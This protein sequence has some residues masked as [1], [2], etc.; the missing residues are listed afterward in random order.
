MINN[1][2]SV[3]IHS[4]FFFLNKANK[5]LDIIGLQNIYIS[6]IEFPCAP[7]WSVWNHRVDFCPPT[8][9]FSR[10]SHKLLS[11]GTALLRVI[12]VFA[13]VS[14]LLLFIVEKIVAIKPSVV[15]HT[16][17]VNTLGGWRQENYKFKLSLGNLVGKT[18]FQSKKLK[19]NR[20]VTWWEGPGFNS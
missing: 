14:N 17:S 20:D 5:I 11:L 1:L 15:I 10:V 9:A 8:P 2:F 3:K 13:C 19:R 12:R 16:Y 6:H 4:F 7:W 18:L